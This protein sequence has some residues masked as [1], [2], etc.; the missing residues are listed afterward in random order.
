MPVHFIP[1]FILL[2]LGLALLALGVVL[3]IHSN[4]GTSP[5]SS[6]PYAFSFIF[7]MSIGTLTVFMHILM[8]VLQMLLL[9]KRF[10]WHQWLQLPVGIIF[11]LLIDSLMWLTQGLS[12]QHYALQLFTC[13]FSCFITALGVCFIIKASLVFLAGEGLYAAISQRFGIDFGS[14]KTYGDITLVSIA[15][16]A[17]LLALGEVVGVREGTI[18]TALLVGTIVKRMLPKL[19]FIQFTAK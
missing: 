18:I 3:S 10:Q 1:R 16:I 12:I 19:S 14:C 7:N 6:V 13:L 17:A 15:V 2:I 5:I 8:I 9:G 11:G 4:L